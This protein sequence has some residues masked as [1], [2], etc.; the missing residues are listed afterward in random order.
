M[1]TW[2]PACAW[3]VPVS[4]VCGPSA[5]AGVAPFPFPRRYSQQKRNEVANG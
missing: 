3:S 5:R 4:T 2:G 1:T